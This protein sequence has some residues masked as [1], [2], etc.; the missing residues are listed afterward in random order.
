MSNAYGG[1]QQQSKGLSITALVLGILSLLFGIL[2]AIPGVIVG[3]IAR[4]KANNNPEHYG[5]SGMALAGLILSYAI[6]IVTIAAIYFF[7]TNPEI[8]EVFKDIMEQAK[9]QQL[10]QLQQ[11][12]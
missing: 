11:P 5:G 9:Q 1:V 12:Q 10:Q 6:I 4:S 8:Q 2:T 7:A 3:H